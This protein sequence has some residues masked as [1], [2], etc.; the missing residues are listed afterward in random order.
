MNTR[1]KYRLIHI[2]IAILLVLYWAQHWWGKTLPENADTTQ[3][4]IAGLFIMIV[5]TILLLIFVVWLFR[6]SIKAISYLDFA[7]IFYF[8][9]SLMSLLSTHSL[10]ALAQLVL[11]SY[12]LWHCVKVGRVAKKAFKARQKS[13]QP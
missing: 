8:L 12:A 13:T 7:L 4:L 6:P 2:A 9:V 11:I 3:W 10:F 1:H 5:K